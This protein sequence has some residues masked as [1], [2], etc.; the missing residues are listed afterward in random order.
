LV[1]NGTFAVDANWTKQSGWTISAGA[2]HAASATS[3]LYQNIAATAQTQYLVT[4]TIAN[5]TAGSVTLGIG[6][7]LIPVTHSANGTYADIVS[8]GGGNDGN[9][10]FSATGFT[11]DIQ[12]VTVYKYSSVGSISLGSLYASE[13]LGIGTTSPLYLLHVGSSAVPNPAKSRLK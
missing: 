10:Y 12:N 8:T 2:A 1:T 7:S 11:G 13:K 9:I 4:W 6:G 3:Y 5:R